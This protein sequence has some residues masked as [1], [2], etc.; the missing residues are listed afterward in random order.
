L[1]FLFK[2]YHMLSPSMLKP[3]IGYTRP[4]CLE[5][6]SCN[7][8]SHLM[9][10]KALGVRD[11]FLLCMS[12]PT[13]FQKLK[14]SL[15]LGEPKTSYIYSMNKDMFATTRSRSKWLEN[16][17]GNIKK[18]KQWELT[19]HIHLK[20]NLAT[21]KCCSFHCIRSY[22]FQHTPKKRTNW[23]FLCTKSRKFPKKKGGKIYNFK[24][25]ID[26]TYKLSTTH[27]NWHP[28]LDWRFL[29]YTPMKQHS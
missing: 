23:N 16:P 1:I 9:L 11:C 27:T 15:T 21:H 19:L 10:C 20:V 5:K 2:I 6:C 8:L 4:F 18:S 24:T 17:L 22:K 7:F 12:L 28:H 26:T 13:E 29:M 25:F 14:V 3:S